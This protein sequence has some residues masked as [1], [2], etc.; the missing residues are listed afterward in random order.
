M[1]RVKIRIMSTR[2]FD[3]VDRST[4]RTHINK[5]G[6][7][8][9]KMVLLHGLGVN[10]AKVPSYFR[11]LLT[12]PLELPVLVLGEIR[13]RTLKLGND[14]AGRKGSRGK[15]T[16]LG[17]ARSVSVTRGVRYFDGARGMIKLEVAR[18]MPKENK[19]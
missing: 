1:E 10:D 11:V 7:T 3:V 17:F 9:E 15:D 12:T 5:S 2:P 19:G 16:K 18:C 6:R 13:H 14:S 4:T 8:E